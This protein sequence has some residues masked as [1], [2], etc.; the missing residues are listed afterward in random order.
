MPGLEL[1]RLFLDNATIAGAGR[2]LYDQNPDQSDCVS[3]SHL[4]TASLLCDEIYIDGS[5]RAVPLKVYDLKD[6]KMKVT[7]SLPAIWTWEKRYPAI[8]D[9]CNITDEFLQRKF[10]FKQDKVVEYLLHTLERLEPGEFEDFDIDLIPSV[11]L[12]DFYFDR[13]WI[14]SLKKATQKASHTRFQ[15][16]GFKVLLYAW[17]GVY[18]HEVS[19]LTGVT[20][21]PNPQRSLFIERFLVAG[22]DVF[23]YDSEALKL[24]G[25]V[26]ANPRVKLVQELA[27]EKEREFGLSLPPLMAYVL[28]NCGK[29]RMEIVENVKKLREL[30]EFTQLRRWV[31]EYDQVYRNA[32]LLRLKKMR[33]EVVNSMANFEKR[34]SISDVRISITP[35]LPIAQIE[36]KGVDGLFGLKIPSFLFT[37]LFQKPYLSLIWN[38][39]KNSLTN[40]F[41]ANDIAK[42]SPIPRDPGSN[43]E[44]VLMES[45]GERVRFKGEDMRSDLRDPDYIV[46][47]KVASSVNYAEHGYSNYLDVLGDTT[48]PAKRI[49]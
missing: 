39:A 24:L 6:N 43:M 29:N 12:S 46:D 14:L 13:D 18:Y 10:G 7:E 20:Y 16:T 48:R 42:L 19:K 5:S 49:K 45:A 1:S 4:I 44:W 8:G 34:M 35:K 32:D 15:D 31:F 25:E 21:Y 28:Q 23:R 38:V 36:V 2:A 17:R 22:S 3:L 40:G 27:K 47:D 41:Y 11:Y 26:I 9:M 37:E 33:Q 30:K